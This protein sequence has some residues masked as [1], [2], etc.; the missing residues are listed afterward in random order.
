VIAALT[1]D[2]LSTGPATFLSSGPIEWTVH[3][4]GSSQ[5][6]A[7]GSPLQFSQVSYRFLCCS[8]SSD[9]EPR[10]R[11]AQLLLSLAID[12]SVR[13]V[14]NARVWTAL[15]AA[16][17]LSC[18]TLQRSLMH[19]AARYLRAIP[20]RPLSGTGMRGRAAENTVI[21][22][23]L[24]PDEALLRRIFFPDLGPLNE[25]VHAS[26]L[27]GGGPLDAQLHG[28]N[29]LQ[30]VEDHASAP[31]VLDL[32][33][34]ALSQQAM[35]LLSVE[36]ERERLRQQQME[37]LRDRRLQ[38]RHSEQ[39]LSPLLGHSARSC[40]R[41][42]SP[43]SSSKKST[44][45]VK[46][47]GGAHARSRSA[48]KRQPRRPLP[49]PTPLPGSQLRLRG[50]VLLKEYNR[51]SGGLAKLTQ[52]SRKREVMC[53][54]RENGLFV[55][56]ANGDELMLI[57]IDERTTL[58]RVESEEVIYVRTSESQVRLS[59]TIPSQ[60]RRWLEALITVVNANTSGSAS[61]YTHNSSS[62]EMSDAG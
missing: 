2:S 42:T 15:V 43:M 24:A 4:V 5:R 32:A 60:T 48:S 10:Q 62:D 8:L 31:E 30:E 34:V 13:E 40:S 50:R 20:L 16:L 35:V 17:K 23:S 6:Q 3:R 59:F 36:L 14:F 47:S 29:L 46:Q 7:S 49:S 61:M 26:F 37:L 28:G 51:R 52:N 56:N 44:N 12:C 27:V 41:S 58:R 45:V 33:P 54:L 57:P 53:S 9:A 22:E 55:V 21:A 11:V 19:V 38:Q 25:L 18:G 1:A 39:I